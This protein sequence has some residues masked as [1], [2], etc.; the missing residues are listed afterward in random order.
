MLHL[1][2]LQFGDD[3]LF[4]LEAKRRQTEIIRNVDSVLKF[5]LV[6]AQG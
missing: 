6:Y 3:T 5:L 2:R 4:L 1:T